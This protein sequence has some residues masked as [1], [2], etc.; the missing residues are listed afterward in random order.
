MRVIVIFVLLLIVCSC[1]NN[2][3]DICNEEKE[4]CKQ[5]LPFVIDKNYFLKVFPVPDSQENTQKSIDT[6]FFAIFIND[7]LLP[8]QDTLIL[9]EISNAFKVNEASIQK[10]NDEISIIDGN[11]LGQVQDFSFYSIKEYNE[12]VKLK[13]ETIVF[14]SISN[15]YFDV[16][17]SNAS[18]TVELVSDPKTY[19]KYLCFVTK[20]KSNWI[21]KKK[22][23]VEIS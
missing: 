21:L 12:Y 7:T 4:I 15:I 2:S 9:E 23:L 16:S 6:I 14:M 11:I 1:T 19:L 17:M 5:V 13:N 22:I 18:F 20:N 3:S 8:I 10:C